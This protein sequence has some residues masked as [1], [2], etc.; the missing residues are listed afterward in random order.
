[1]QL[2]HYSE[3]IKDE[4]EARNWDNHSLAVAMCRSDSFVSDLLD[5]KVE[6]TKDLAIDLGGAFWTSKEVWLE[7]AK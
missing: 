6:M 7:L 5:G 1:M 3:F 4:M 2:F